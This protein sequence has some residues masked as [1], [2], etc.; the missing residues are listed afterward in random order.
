MHLGTE[1]DSATPIMRSVPKS[2]YLNC[3]CNGLS[4]RFASQCAAQ[5]ACTHRRMDNTRSTAVF[6]ASPVAT[7]PVQQRASA[8]V[9]RGSSRGA[10]YCGPHPLVRSDLRDSHG[11]NCGIT[12]RLLAVA[13][14]TL[15]RRV[16]H[17]SETAAGPVVAGTEFLE[18]PHTLATV[19]V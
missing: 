18:Q 15:R 6:I 4:E 10:N 16:T 17:A 11:M 1:D 2:G 7:V 3:L 14:I 8:G 5:V 9:G 19:R 13:R 12:K